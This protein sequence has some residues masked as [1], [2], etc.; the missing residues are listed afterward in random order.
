MRFFKD[1][2]CKQ[3]IISTIKSVKKK[4]QLTL[5]N[6]NLAFMLL[7][8]SILYLYISINTIHKNTAKNISINKLKEA[9]NYKIQ[10]KLTGINNS[11]KTEDFA[12][13]HMNI[14][15]NDNNNSLNNTF[16]KINNLNSINKKIN[17]LISGLNNLTNKLQDRKMSGIWNSINKKNN[18]TNFSKDSGRIEVVFNKQFSDNINKEKSNVLLL[19]INIYDD[20][21]LDKWY[22][23]HILIPFKNLSKE[24][25]T[26]SNDEL[27]HINKNIFDKDLNLSF[28]DNY[29][30]GEG[31]H[32]IGIYGEE[33][34][35][36]DE[37]ASKYNLY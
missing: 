7:S 25:N 13:R 34:Y 30:K 31:L 17:S 2:I 5:Q 26:I 14:I 16:N 35:K 32:T 1:V 22:E 10:K 29:L 21:Y 3:R 37:V 23:F 33:F 20:K 12:R 8:L 24:F 36:N 28:G 6:T 9:Y 19:F 18:I 15:I 27:E 11:N 4:I